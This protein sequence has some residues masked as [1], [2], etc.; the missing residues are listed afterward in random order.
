MPKTI[1]F[2]S[3]PKEIQDHLKYVV[4]YTVN[5]RP[6]AVREKL[7]HLKKS[8]DSY[9]SAHGTN[10]SMSALLDTR[11][12]ELCCYGLP[13]ES[14]HLTLLE[15]AV[16][17]TNPRFGVVE[18]AKE[19]A[20]ALREYGAPETERTAYFP[21]VY[22][23]LPSLTSISSFFKSAAAS[24]LSTPVSEEKKQQPR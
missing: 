10:Y 15:D 21:N 13:G 1:P 8:M 20:A 19:I 12:S 17:G 9:N 24:I 7:I 2:L 5:F 18:K 3:L 16:A 23:S 14:D 4:R 22:N 6:D 11:I